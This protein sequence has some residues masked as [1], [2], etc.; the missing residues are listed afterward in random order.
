MK[1]LSTLIICLFTIGVLS[2]LNSCKKDTETA[3]TPVPNYT[4]FKITSVKITAMPFLNAN[5]N[6]WDFAGGPD[7]FFNM[8]DVNS[9]VLLNGSGSRFTDIS[10]SDLP[11]TWNLVSAYQITNIG[12]T[13]YVTVYDYD[14]PDPDDLIGYVGFKMEDHKSG[15]PTTMS[16]S[17]A[18]IS[19]TIIGS[20]Y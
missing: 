19:V 6:S 9:V 12:V 11:L 3:P 17:N 16:G 13:H 10:S 8:E 20:W 7:V 4:N 2:V 5:N 14:S 18:G 15:Y 1:K